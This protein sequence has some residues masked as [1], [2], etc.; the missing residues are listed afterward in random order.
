MD[1]DQEAP[2]KM[3][4]DDAMELIGVIGDELEHQGF[5][6]AEVGAMMVAYGMVTCYQE[7]GQGGVAIAISG[8]YKTIDAREAQG[9]KATQ[10]Q[11]Q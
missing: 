1:N 8:A 3:T 5:D 11:R 9:I 2:N 7:G 6:R 4:M 10:N